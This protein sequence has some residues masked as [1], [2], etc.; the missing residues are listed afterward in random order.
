MTNGVFNSVFGAPAVSAVSGNGQNGID[1]NITGTSGIG[2]N[3][4]TSS[5]GDNAIY[6]ESSTSQCVYGICNGD[7][8]GV[9]GGSGYGVV[10]TSS[11]G[12]GVHAVGGGASP[13]VPSITQAAIFAEG[14]PGLGVYATS[15]VTGVSAE[16]TSGTGISAKS[17]TGIAI[18]ASSDSGTGVSAGA[19]GSG[20]GV[21]A[22]SVS[23]FGV[24][25]LGAGASL[26]STPPITQAAI[27]AEGGLTPGVYATSESGNG[28]SGTQTGRP[29]GLIIPV[30][31]LHEQD[32]GVF[33][34][35]LAVDGN[36]VIGEANEG[37]D[38]YGVW[39]R[40][41]SGYAGFFD[42]KV[43]VEGNVLVNGNLAA[44][45]TKPFVQAHPTDPSREIVYVA[46]EGGEAGTYVRGTG[47]LV[48]GKAV[49]ELPEHFALVTEHQDL[50]IQLT[51][52][53]TWLQ[54]YVVELDTAQLVVQEAQGQSGAFDYLIHGIRRGYAQHE[55]IRPRR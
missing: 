16:S 51:P 23:G 35:S 13:S 29:A 7:N 14:G 19:F 48:D 41:T 22:L 15:E 47:Q 9:S 6:A 18:N 38:A 42:G 5:L 2:L 44:T 49:V 55:V 43:Q 53:G 8:D 11:T 30:P 25:A 45:G 34:T 36:G 24:H 17:Q 33:G 39:G 54:L 1:I 4:G 27:F 10:A 40:S 32:A 46:L 3:V 21:Y 50:T 31:I 20:T 52:R 37:G 26:T 12:I 28:V